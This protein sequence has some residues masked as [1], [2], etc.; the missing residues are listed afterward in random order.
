MK[1][2]DLIKKGNKSYAEVA[3]IYSKNESSIC[4]IMKKEKKCAHSA[5]IP[6]SAK[7]VA[8]VREKGSVKMKGH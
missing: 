1:V 5:L 8:T 6:Q 2:L 3:K 4:Q 7:V